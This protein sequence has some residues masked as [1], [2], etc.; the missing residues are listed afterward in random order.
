MKKLVLSV[1][2][3]IS[4]ILAHQAGAQTTQWWDN[5]G[6]NPA[7]DGTWDTNSPSWSDSAALTDATAPFTN[8][9]YVIFS[10]GST[11]ISTLNIS[12]TGN[13]TCSG[14]G[15]GTTIT[16]AAS[17][18]Y[19]TNLNL[20]DGGGSISLPDGMWPFEC[21]NGPAA[22][23]SINIYAPI[24]GTGGIVQHNNAGL[25][26]YGNNTYSGGTAV[27]GGQIIYYNNDNS[28]GSGPISTSG[29][30]T[31][32]WNKSSG[33]VTLT[34]GFDINSGTSILNFAA[35]NTICSGPWTLGTTLQ[36][37]NNAA[38]TPVT[39][40]GPISG[41]SGLDLQCNNAG[42]S[43]TLS[44]ENT[45]TGQTGIGWLGSGASMVYVSSI[46]SV[47]NPA[48]Q[49]SSS[50]GVPSS[51]ATGTITMGYAGFPGQ[52]I[53]TGPGETSDRVISLTGTTGANAGAIIE[54]DGAG[55]L[56]LTSSFI[57]PTNGAKTV[58]LQGSST[59]TNT[60]AGAIP[61]SGSGNTSLTKA[62][63]GTWVLTGTNTYTGA[64]KVNAGTLIIAG[65][66]KLANSTPITLNG[67]LDFTST[68]AQTLSGV[69]SG[70]GT[71]N[72]AAPNTT[73]TLSGTANTFTGLFN[74]NAGILSFNSD[75]SLGAAPASFVPNAITLNGGPL[76]GLRANANNITIN[77]NRGIT[78]GENGGE[79]HVAANDTCTYNGVISG[80]G[81]FQAGQNASTGLGVLV[82]GGVETYTGN[83]VIATGT[84]RLSS[85]ASIA[86]SSGILMSNAATFDV[87]S[88]NPFAM[89]GNNAFFTAIGTTSTP[90]VLGASGGNVDF[91]SQAVN[92][93]FV[94][95][96][97]NGDSS[98]PALKISQGTLVL[99]GNAIYVTNASALN[100]SFGTYTLIQGV[101]GG[102]VSVTGPLTL[103][104][105]GPSLAPFTTASLVV[106]GG[107]LNLVVS[108]T[109]APGSFTSVATQA[110][111]T[112]LLNFS[113][114]PGAQYMIQSTTNLAPPVV[115]TSISTNTAGVDGTFQ[116]NDLTSTNF[117]MQYYRAL[118]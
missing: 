22:S 36:L 81:V 24:T 64:T 67:T 73:T 6:A 35:G 78:L 7:T 83:T 116:F 20:N 52:L 37:K 66:G 16:G 96:S 5:N 74:V 1:A 84:L 109:A 71:F 111:G 69:L 60:I 82:L 90:S 42:A 106:S 51:A 21:G 105:F 92:L 97:A 95:A 34:N 65:T 17:G 26:L 58:T 110:D 4:G 62:Q 114:T 43:I 38:G 33:I 41:A 13:V 80:S 40:S 3:V 100:L 115:W 88:Q 68:T 30:A 103:N 15:D 47:A 86:S 50:L 55:P 28:F 31:S 75:A 63:A 113:G 72:Q 79:I 56:V 101:N 9:N 98:H 102:G 8:G 11:P 107:N 49:P 2:F 54:M 87:S 23:A 46:N 76:S 91:S 32:F 25:G 61:N 112:I 45:Y 57:V 77:A 108:S 14:L 39:I 93:S 27:T 44:G 70:N 99:N 94:P 117:P 29:G 104:Y 85:G 10:A 19:A 48:Q 118:P 12:V 59:A 53:Y 18:A 89:S